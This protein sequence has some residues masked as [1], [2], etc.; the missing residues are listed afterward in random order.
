MAVGRK[1]GAHSSRLNRP[2]PT[3]LRRRCKSTLAIFKFK[4]IQSALRGNPKFGP[5]QRRL[6]PSRQLELASGPSDT[7]TLPVPMA[8]D[9]GSVGVTPLAR[10]ASDRREPPTSAAGPG[11]R[12]SRLA[13]P[14]TSTAES[15][16]LA[17]NFTRNFAESEVPPLDFK[18]DKAASH[19]LSATVGISLPVP[20]PATRRSGQAGPGQSESCQ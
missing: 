9:S 1:R 14:A 11:R 12:R 19:G 15:G 4:L 10:A 2:L 18:L 7:A 8:S 13:S 6:T 5:D 3:P 17:C 16:R 20:V